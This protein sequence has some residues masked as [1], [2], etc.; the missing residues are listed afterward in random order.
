MQNKELE[1][2]IDF[3]L[4]AAL[5]KCENFEDAQ[6]LTQETLLSALVFISGGKII[7][8][9]KA[10]LVT[11]LNRKYYDMLRKKYKLPTVTVG[12]EFD[13]TDDCDCFNEM[14]LDIS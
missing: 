1:N 13:I 7:D 9:I 3:L 10:W 4:S 8:N 12:D 6:D 14:G 11:V 2:Q 5:R